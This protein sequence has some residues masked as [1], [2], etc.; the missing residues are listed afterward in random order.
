MNRGEHLYILRTDP[1]I[2]TPE[3]ME[4]LK[5]ERNQT[6]EKETGIPVAGLES[7]IPQ[8]KRKE[9]DDDRKKEEPRQRKK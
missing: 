3:A 5:N 8:G 6:V 1:R 2:K 9:K 7:E 4:V